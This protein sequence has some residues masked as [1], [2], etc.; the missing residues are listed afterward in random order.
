[1]KTIFMYKNQHK[2]HSSEQG[3]LANTSHPYS[4]MLWVCK[5]IVPRTWSSATWKDRAVQI[6]TQEH[7][8][9]HH[10]K[11]LLALS[12]PPEGA[13]RRSCRVSGHVHP[14]DGDCLPCCCHI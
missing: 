6:S 5:P 3:L 9:K 14:E 2:S 8:A 4:G 1:M 11:L 13:H 7:M 12:V 10:I